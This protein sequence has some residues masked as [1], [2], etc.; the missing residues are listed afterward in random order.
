[1]ALKN[2]GQMRFWVDVL[3]PVATGEKDR[4]GRKKTTYEKCLRLPCAVRDMSAR[5]FLAQDAQMREKVVTF[6]TRYHKDVREDM[7]I[8]F[9]GQDWDILYINHLGYGRYMDIKAKA[10]EGQAVSYGENQR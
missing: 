4:Y 1:M 10:V 6:S 7:R 9:R 3:R 2:A 8:R 5:E